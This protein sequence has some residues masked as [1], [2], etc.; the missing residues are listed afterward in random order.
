M[1]SA[2][3][4]IQIGSERCALLFNGRELTNLTRFSLLA[5]ELGVHTVYACAGNFPEFGP[6]PTN[7][8]SNS[9][10]PLRIHVYPKLTDLSC[11]LLSR[12]FGGITTLEVT[13]T[14]DKTRSRFVFVRPIQRQLLDALVALGAEVE[15]PGNPLEDNEFDGVKERTFK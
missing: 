7:A 2:Q 6:A 13:V 15:M 8:G 9:A 5:S 12:P 1:E 4:S 11:T 3:L 14:P 10:F